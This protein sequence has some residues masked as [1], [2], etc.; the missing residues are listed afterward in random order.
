MARC[1]RSSRITAS[2]RPTDVTCASQC[3]QWPPVPRG[4]LL[5]VPTVLVPRSRRE[6]HWCHGVRCWCTA[7]ERR[8]VTPLENVFP[9]LLPILALGGGDVCQCTTLAYIPI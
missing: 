4:R 1:W 7:I 9:T 5:A 8:L 2:L 3:S 6:P